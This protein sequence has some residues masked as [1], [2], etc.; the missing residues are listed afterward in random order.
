MMNFEMI[1]T[2]CIDGDDL[3]WVPFTPYDDR[4]M[5]KYFKLD[6]VQGEMVLL[7]RAPADI[8]MARHHHTGTVIVYT[9]SGSWK[10]KEHDWVAKPGSCVYETAST[11]HTPEGVGTEDVVTFVIVKGELNYLDDNDQIIAVENWRTA[12]DRYL[13]YCQENNIEARDLTSFSV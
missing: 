3:P 13:N 9:I 7:M 4:V 5:Q 12:M 2:G 6:P 11:R 1:D 8:D 10:Y